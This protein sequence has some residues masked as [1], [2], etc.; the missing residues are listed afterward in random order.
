M[1]KT[2]SLLVVLTLA[3]GIMMPSAIS[4]AS[5]A[6]FAQ[7]NQTITNVTPAGKQL[8]IHITTVIVEGMIE[9]IC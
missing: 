2:K 3:F 7:K 1:R 6:V 9:Q 5:V 4:A 8:L